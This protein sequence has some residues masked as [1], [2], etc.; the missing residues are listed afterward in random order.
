MNA[1]ALTLT[2]GAF[3]HSDD[4]EHTGMRGVRLDADTGFPSG[5]VFSSA[6]P[7]VWVADSGDVE[8]EEGR[9]PRDVAAAWFRAV[10]D[11]LTAA[12]P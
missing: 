9:F 10:A 3:N 1:T 8:F 7:T 6:F 12:T 2:I 5:R 11:Y 4:P